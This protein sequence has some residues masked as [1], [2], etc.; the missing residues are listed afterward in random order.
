MLK[1]PASNNEFAGVG[2]HMDYGFRRQDTRTGRFISVDPLTKKYPMLTP[3]QFASNSPIA[4]I[5]LDGLEHFRRWVDIF[6]ATVD[7]IF[8]GAQAENAKLRAKMIAHSLNQNLNALSP[9]IHKIE[10]I[11]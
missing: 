10:K 9:E 1:R 5:D 11:P 3:Y 8:V 4:G 2:N 7:Q 6:S